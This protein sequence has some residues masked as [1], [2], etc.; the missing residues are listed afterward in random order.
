MTDEQAPFQ[1]QATPA[2]AAPPTPP[3]RSFRSTLAVAAAGVLL[4]LGLVASFSGFVLLSQP[5]RPDLGPVYAMTALITQAA[6]LLVGV[7]NI[8]AALGIYL[9]L[10]WSR[11]LAVALSI[12]GL[13]LSLVFFIGPLSNFHVPALDPLML[14]TIAA[15]A[16]YAYSLLAMLVAGSHFRPRVGA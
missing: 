9:H 3:G 15:I 13:V 5:G 12:V 6:L 7:L 16:G 1:D 2:R 14:A 4:V 11:R 10:G 8:G